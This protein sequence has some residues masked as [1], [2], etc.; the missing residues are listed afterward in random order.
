MKRL[1]LILAASLIVNISLF[2]LVLSRSNE[3]RAPHAAEISTSSSPPPSARALR[4]SSDLSEEDASS[5][6]RSQELLAID[7]LPTL[8]A[9]LRMA[10]F[11]PMDIRGIVSARLAEQF[12]ARRKAAVAHL[13]VVPYWQGISSFPK[14]P[15][16]GAEITGLFREQKAMLKQ[17]L[18]SDAAPADEWS[19]ML[20][21]REYDYLTPDK[22]DRM[23]SIL[24]D[25]KELRSKVFRNSYGVRL[26]ADQEKLQLIE[27][28][29][30]ADLEALF[31]ANELE[32]YEM[33]TTTIANIL[34]NNLRS[35][36][37][38]EEEYRTIY[39]LTEAANPDPKNP[40]VLPLR[41]STDPDQLHLQNEIAEALGPARAAVFRLTNEPEYVEASRFTTRMNLPSTLTPQIY[42]TAIDFKERLRTIQSNNTLAVE[43]RTSQLKALA[44][45]AEQQ[46]TRLLGSRGFQAYEYQ[47]GKWIKNLKGQ[48]EN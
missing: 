4:A 32:A 40:R 36:K 31:T 13:E 10:G 39:R 14:N 27:E 1:P 8:V 12:G 30:R 5:L 34:R 6:I 15:E 42:S 46:F 2:A 20:R 23:E 19:Q 3:Q 45:E 37:P 24:E 44:I 11:H 38:T 18:G 35:F 21:Q 43:T 29:Q 48:S 33:R 47:G 7:H 22:V 26:P 41:Q 17:L 9:R 28:E 16:T 25:Y